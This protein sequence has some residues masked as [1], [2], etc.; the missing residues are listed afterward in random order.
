M[1]NWEP[2]AHTERERVGNPPPKTAR[3]KVLLYSAKGDGKMEWMIPAV[4]I[5]AATTVFGGSEVSPI[6]VLAIH[7]AKPVSVALVRQADYVAIPVTI[8]SEQKEPSQRF[9]DI[10][11][12]KRLIQD[13]A[14]ENKKIMI[15]DGPFFLS[16]RPASKMGFISS[17]SSYEQPSTA[18]L[19]IMIPLD[20]Q[21]P[22]V[23]AAASEITRFVNG[24]KFGEKTQCNLGQVQLAV[25][26]PEQHRAALLQL[27]A[28]DIRKTKE[29]MGVKGNLSVDG[30][31]SPVIVRQLDETKVE[32][33]LNY[34]L[35][36]NWAE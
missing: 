31:Q 10:R 33:L 16:A 36:L 4:M 35:T 1:G 3:T 24:I 28:Q 8:V 14:K 7:D 6:Y 29:Q 11:A 27:I 22:D 34:S 15:K 26:D 23:F 18:N 19:N 21:V 17:Y 30:L 20:L 9:D 12:A 13:K 25:A 5:A 2:A 32:L